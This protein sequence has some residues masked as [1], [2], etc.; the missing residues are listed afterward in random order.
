LTLSLVGGQGKFIAFAQMRQE[1]NANEAKANIKN[2]RA[3]T[4]KITE[5]SVTN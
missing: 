1:E 5:N 3:W 2:P 4:R